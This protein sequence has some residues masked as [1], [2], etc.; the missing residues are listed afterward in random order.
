MQ[1]DMNDETIEAIAELLS[2][3]SDDVLNS[4]EFKWVSTKITEAL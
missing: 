4:D 3:T 2:N 1:T